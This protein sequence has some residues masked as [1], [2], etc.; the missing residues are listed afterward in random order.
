MP[1]GS[2][3][4]ATA[5]LPSSTSSS[6]FISFG[7]KLTRNFVPRTAATETGVVIM[8]FDAGLVMCV[9]CASER[10]ASSAKRRSIDSVSET[11]RKRDRRIRLLDGRVTRLASGSCNVTKPFAPVST[12]SPSSSFNPTEAGVRTAPDTVPTAPL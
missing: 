5:T 4:G 8:N 10:P 9:T 12:R 3:F 6:A 7:M 11:D 1:E 2:L